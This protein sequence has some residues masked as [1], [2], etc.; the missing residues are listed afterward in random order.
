MLAEHYGRTE[1]RALAQWISEEP[2]G[3]YDLDAVIRRLLNDE[4][5][6][7]IFGHTDW[8]GLRLA[9]NSDTLIPRPETSELVDAILAD[10]PADRSL[11]VL[12]MCTGSGCI[13]I[14]LRQRRPNWQVSGCDISLNALSCA[15]Q[16]AL[17][18]L[19]PTT[20]QSEQ[21]VPALYHLSP[22][23]NNLPFFFPCDI[24]QDGDWM[25]R[26]Y[27]VIVSNPPYIADSERAT[28]ADN[29]LMYEPH[30]A[31]FVPDA[32]PLLFYRRIAS[33]HM[34]PVLYFEVNERLAAETAEVVRL[35]GYSSTHIIHDLCGKERILKAEI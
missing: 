31:L 2:E 8:R 11:S 28:M 35:Q 32:D 20:P 25:Q 21:P 27:D 10:Y 26:R 9:L 12:D 18:N 34:A 7:Y 19:S 1:A 22:I 15:Q 6:Q 5:I 24:L 29:V 14:A 17:T 4:P 23:T 13:A 3:S 16:N 33:L 30:R